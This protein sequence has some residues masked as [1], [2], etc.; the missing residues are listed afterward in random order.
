MISFTPNSPSQLSLFE[1]NFGAKLNKENRWVKLACELPW[2][3]LCSI[4][5]RRMNRLRGAPSIDARIIIGALIV[6]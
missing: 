5:R 2:E 6:I 1:D 4:Y 3:K